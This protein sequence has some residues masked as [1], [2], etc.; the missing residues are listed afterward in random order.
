MCIITVR[1]F[2]RPEYFKHTVT[3]LADCRGLEKYH[4]LF[5]IDFSSSKI[6][7]EYVSTIEKFLPNHISKTI[8]LYTSRVGCYGNAKEA[9]TKANENSTA[10]FSEKF[11]YYFNDIKVEKP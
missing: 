10:N 4:I 6:Q 5:N 11:N 7:N 1:G 3:H 2:N 9:F 8:D